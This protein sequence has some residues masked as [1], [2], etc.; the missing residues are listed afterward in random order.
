[1]ADGSRHSMYAVVETTYGETPNN[2]ALEL[3]RL[4]GTTLGLRKDSF[5]SDE[6]RS[7]RQISDF[8]LGANQVGGDINFELSADTFDKLLKGALLSDADWTSPASTGTTTL[9]AT[10]GTFTRASG[11]FVTDG[12]EVDQMVIS[13]GFATSGNNGRWVV[14]AVAATTLTV[15]PLDGQTQ[16]IEAGDADELII[17]AEAISCG[18]L[19][20]SFSLV[21]YFADIDSGDKPYYIY[22]GCEVNTLKINIA[23]NAKITGSMSVIGQSQTLAEDLTSLGTPTYPAATT[24]NV[25]DSFTGLLREAGST[26]AVLTELSFTLN[27]GLAPRFVVG[28]TNTILP[29]I[30]R[31]NLTGTFTA[32]FEDSSL[33]E[34]F[35]NET[36]SYIDFDMPDSDGNAQRYRIPRI[37]YTGGQPDVSGEGP[38]TLSMPFQALLDSTTGTNLL[39]ERVT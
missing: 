34:K 16:S 9:S 23:A 17:A 4:T 32:Y 2:P 24:T 21:R 35:L 3:V 27:N 12:F 5:L 38:V 7:D 25:L 15:T 10:A 22:K 6:I 31:S 8:R 20:E 33:V 29:S 37:A 11:S 13:S 36:E 1:M 30:Q 26:I 39:I 28:S 19:R 14:T 18:V